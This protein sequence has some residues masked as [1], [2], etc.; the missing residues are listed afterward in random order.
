MWKKFALMIL[1]TLGAFFGI[2]GG[3]ELAISQSPVAFLG[4]FVV[5]L[6]VLGFLYGGHK[7]FK[8]KK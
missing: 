5:I 8:K 6:S 3:R 7:I 1:I 4:S 2:I